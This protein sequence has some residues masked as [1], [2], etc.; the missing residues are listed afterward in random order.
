MKGGFTDMRLSTI[1]AAALLL[2]AFV[3]AAPARSFAESMIDGEIGYKKGLYYKSADG[4]F[5]IRQN[6]RIQ[7]RMDDI[8]G[9]NGD[10][11]TKSETDF[12]IRRLKLKYGGHAFEKWLKYGFQLAGSA[13]RADREDDIEIEDAFVVFAKNR[14]A[15]LKAGRYKIPYERE[16][17]NSSSALQFVD[18]SH[19]KQFVIDADRADG[20][21]VGG[22][23]GN[24]F[25]YRTGLFQYDDE[26][27]EGAERMLFAGRLQAN[28][29]CGEL[30]YSSGSFPAGGDYKIKPNFAK[31]PILAVGVGWFYYRGAEQTFTATGAGAIEPVTRTLKDVNTAAGATVDAVFQIER[32]NIEAAFYYGSAK[33]KS[34]VNANLGADN[35]AGGT[36]ENA[37]TPPSVGTNSFGHYAYRVQGGYMVLPELEIAARFASAKYDPDSSE[38]DRWEWTTGLNY[39][40]AKHRAK[41][42]F[43]YTYGSEEN[44]AGRGDK[45]NTFRAQVQLYL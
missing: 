25:A 14:A 38:K 20:V 40:I 4:R 43:D 33:S 44:R 28:L 31:V 5:K 9:A 41:V 6:F 15:D 11:G 39:Y 18:R 21:S 30:K 22:I 42:Q 13:G 23:L 24:R 36:G 37:D 8:S 45:T 2:A 12:M 29:C 27:F 7:F 19:I 16:V 34:V 32:A 17:L 26:K 3:I 35:I 10:S 1:S